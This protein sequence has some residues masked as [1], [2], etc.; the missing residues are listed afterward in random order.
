MAHAMKMHG[1]IQKRTVPTW[2]GRKMTSLRPSRSSRIVSRKE[3]SSKQHQ[4][5]EKYS[6]D[7]RTSILRLCRRKR[8]SARMPCVLIESSV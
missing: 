3:A 4:R 1:V 7:H 8:P 5:R 6:G 2:I